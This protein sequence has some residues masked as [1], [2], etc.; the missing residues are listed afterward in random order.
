MGPAAAGEN[1]S[2]HTGASGEHTLSG[3]AYTGDPDAL[4]ER[5]ADMK[6]MAPTE[7]LP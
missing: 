6:G 1:P 7:R 4:P 3:G 5:S 2:I